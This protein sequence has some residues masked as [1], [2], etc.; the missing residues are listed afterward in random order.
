VDL[1]LPET[2]FDTLNL[3]ACLFAIE[4]LFEEKNVRLPVFASVTITD[5][6]GR[7]L[8]GQTLDAFL[9]SISHASL[10][11]VGINCAFGPDLMAPFVKTARH[12]LSVF[13]YP[14]RL[15]EQVRRLRSRSAWP[16]LGA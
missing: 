1:L 9:A 3:K 2:T 15:S 4:K 10:T 8:S 11:A 12:P 13:A 16:G 14:T 7:T 5:R 6:S